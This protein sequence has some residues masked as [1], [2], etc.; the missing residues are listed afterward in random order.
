MG[1]QYLLPIIQLTIFFISFESLAFQ[2]QEY[3]PVVF[4]MAQLYD[5]NPVKGNV[6]EVKAVVYNEDNSINYESL[7]TIGR[8]GCVESFTLNQK[9]D[10]YLS[11]LNNHLVVKRVKNKL[12]GTD[13]SGPIEMTIGNNCMILSRKDINGE[14]IYQYNKDGIIIGSVLAD[15]KEKFSENN[16]NEFKLPTTIKYYKDN[17][18]I[19]E[20]IMTY[21]KDMQKPFDFFMEILVLGQVILQ[22]D[23]KCSYDNQNI[24][25]KCN[26][27][28]TLNSED[29]NIKLLKNSTTEALFY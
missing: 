12:V 5:F 16:Y 19:S 28:L 24:A 20:T 10:E 8:D 23:S 9:Q 18:V 14:L 11:R 22:V 29:K 2:K 3:N 1:N 7:L 6:K 26:F 15:T 27:V 17:K 25:Y 21:G 4:N 13:T